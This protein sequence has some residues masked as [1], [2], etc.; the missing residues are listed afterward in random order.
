MKY[1]VSLERT[2]E[3]YAVHVPGLPGCWAQGR[4]ENEALENIKDAIQTYLE[5]VEE[6]SIEEFKKCISLTTCWKS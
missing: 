2:S 6:L 1:R 4:T 3:G 5:T